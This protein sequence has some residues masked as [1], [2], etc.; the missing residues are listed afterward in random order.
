MRAVDDIHVRDAQH[1]FRRGDAFEDE[2]FTIV[3]HRAQAGLLRDA[4]DPERQLARTVR[5]PAE[6]RYS[7]AAWVSVDPRAS[8]A[9]LDRVA[10]TRGALRATSSSRFEN[11]PRNRASG[12]FDG[13][14]ALG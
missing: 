4:R 5:P 1:F 11:R 14:R 13:S 12:V 3:A 2:A 7:G 6:R 8:D 10:G 9:A